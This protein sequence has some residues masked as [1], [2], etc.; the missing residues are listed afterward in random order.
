MRSRSNLY[1]ALIAATLGICLGVA[2]VAL[3]GTNAKGCTTKL[4]F[5]NDPMLPT[6]VL[7]ANINC[8]DQSCTVV[9]LGGGLYVCGCPSNPG[10][11]PFEYLVHGSNN[12]TTF[13][14]WDGLHTWGL[15][16]VR[17]NC[18]VVCDEPVEVLSSGTATSC[19][20]PGGT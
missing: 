8:P 13:I 6:G 7:C 12:C 18:P 5:P 10:G 11:A 9:P 20:C 2:D 4:L 1:I 15:T 17:D 19:K 14:E 16:C 3:A